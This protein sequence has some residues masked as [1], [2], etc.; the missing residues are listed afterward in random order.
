MLSKDELAR[1]RSLISD[2]VGDDYPAQCDARRELL[3]LLPTALP[4]LLRIAEAV[5]ELAAAER[6]CEALRMMQ[7][8]EGG[9]AKLR[10]A[11]ERRSVA[12]TR[13]VRIDLGRSG[14]GEA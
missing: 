3:S 2:Y 10:A 7:W 13:L 4:T 9:I 12:W 6:E 11:E 1:L 5:A 8:H 14:E